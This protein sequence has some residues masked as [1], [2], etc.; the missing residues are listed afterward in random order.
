MT[1]FI[2]NTLWFNDVA[3]VDYN[4][5]ETPQSLIDALKVP[6]DKWSFTITESQYE[7]M[8]NQKTAG[9]GFGYTTDFRVF[10]VRI[11]SP[12]DLA[13]LQRGDLILK[14]NGKAA[15]NENIAAASQNLK[16]P[17]TF[18]VE[19]L[20]V[21]ENIVVTPKEYTFKVTKGKI[22][23]GNIGYLRYDCFYLYFL[24]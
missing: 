15:S 7:D 11:S 16:V 19:R 17:T 20:G 14:I 2:Q 12:A 13:G 10:L 4:A 8:V 22:L 1:S 21:N 24:P 18:T 6:Q 23:S 3:D 5:Y 9:F